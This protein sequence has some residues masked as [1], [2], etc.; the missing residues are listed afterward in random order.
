MTFFSSW[1]D[2]E[3]RRRRRRRRRVLLALVLTGA[4]LWWALGDRTA[5]RTPGPSGDDARP[6]GPA[7]EE[8]VSAPGDMEY[9]PTGQDVGQTGDDDGQEAADVRDG[10]GGGRRLRD[11]VAVLPLSGPF[12]AEGKALQRGM[13]LAAVTASSEE[14]VHIHYVDGWLPENA[15]A[16]AVATAVAHASVG[17]VLAHVPLSR[18]DALLRPAVEK[19]VLAVSLVSGHDALIQGRSTVAFLGPDEEA[20]K[21]AAELLAAHR[22]SGNVLVM[23]DG[24][25]YGARWAD[26][27]SREAARLGMKLRRAQWNEREAAPLDMTEL[28][29]AVFLVGSPQWAAEAI[30]IL[31]L[32]G[33]RAL[34]VL[35]YCLG[36]PSLEDAL[37]PLVDTV[38]FVVPMAGA[39][40]NG[41][42]DAGFR[43]RFRQNFWKDPDWMA[44]VGHDAV[45]WIGRVFREQGDIS[46][47]ELA[48]KVFS[49]NVSP[50]T[51]TGVAGTL[52]VG[53]KGRVERRCVL[54]RWK[55]GSFE[56]FSE[57]S[58][59]VE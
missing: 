20:A 10:S 30:R 27:F 8:V 2:S 29:R 43:D 51:F 18:W 31:H 53:D 32:T 59:R 46:A 50:R 25:S 56:P 9:G 58:S 39:V 16:E 23:T 4:A 14:R 34:Y 54:A 40:P 28:P 37:G 7:S 33:C 38:R 48:E 36:R 24:S 49:G 26:V 22:A 1:S 17:A 21:A 55:D 13:K 15:A 57:E 45:R 41:P 35:P 12:S 3:K 44:S 19:G 5:V 11:V 42:H 6:G 47:A 52:T